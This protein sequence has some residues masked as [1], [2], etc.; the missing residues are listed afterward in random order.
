MWIPWPDSVHLDFRCTDSMVLLL[1][2][3]SGDGASN[4]GVELVVGVYSVSAQ[5]T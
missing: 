1:I 2:G 3:G 5:Y 4:S